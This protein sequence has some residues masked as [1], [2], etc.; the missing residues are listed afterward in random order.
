MKLHGL[1]LA[2]GESKRLG[3]PKQ[4]IKYR[5]Q[6]LLSS[7]EQKLLECCDQVFVVLGFQTEL[8][9]NEISSAKII[10]NP[11]W[12]SG[13]GSSL[14]MGA[15]IASKQA[16]GLLIALCDQPLIEM[17]HY[18]QLS[19]IFKQH[20]SQIIATR[21]QQQNGVPAIFP[22]KYFQQ[23]T[24]IKNK[25]GA[26]FLIHQNNEQVLNIECQAASYDIDYAEDL[27]KLASSSV[28]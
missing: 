14:A 4:L 16:D 11:D 20:P 22:E 17:T 10:I 8:F 21:Y 9:K 27:S 25:S 2:A 26:Q 5:N 23:L 6:T 7:I 28:G 3:Q 12:Q 15:S 1:I 13:M 24:D 18:K 19:Q